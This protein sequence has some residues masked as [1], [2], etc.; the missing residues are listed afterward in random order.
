MN[1][2][3]KIQT[4]KSLLFLL[5][6][7]SSFTTGLL[8]GLL[9]PFNFFQS[10]DSFEPM[11]YQTENV[12]EDNLYKSSPDQRDTSNQQPPQTQKESVHR[13]RKMLEKTLEDE[14]SLQHY[15]VSIGRYTT[16]NQ[17]N[18]T[19]INLKQKYPEWDISVYPINKQQIVVIGSFTD[20]ESAQTFLK[21]L[22]KKSQFLKAQ[23]VQIPHKKKEE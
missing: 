23:V 4:P 3:N 15:G 9:A 2:E 20:K 14:L 7:L 8:I 13:Y 10:K 1:T 12:T 16:V 5:V 11:P 6:A 18:D 19:A 22:P 21:N 17:A